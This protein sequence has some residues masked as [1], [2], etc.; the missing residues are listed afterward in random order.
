MMLII[1]LTD[2]WDLLDVTSGTRISF[3]WFQTLLHKIS[4][5]HVL[6]EVI[7]FQIC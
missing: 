3:R 4:K 5:Y 1:V 2:Y 7:L 6:A